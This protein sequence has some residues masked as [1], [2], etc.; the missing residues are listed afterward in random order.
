MLERV[1]E[2]KLNWLGARG[3][4][5]LKLVTPGNSHVMDRMI[6]WPTW[7]PAPPVYVEIKRPGEQPRPAQEATADEWR[8]RGLDVRDY[9]DTPEKVMQLCRAL[10]WEAEQRYVGELPWERMT[11]KP[12]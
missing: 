8:K 1:V 12:V 10:L 9:C 5:H 11:Q 4:R 6:L 3:F 7:S 2:S